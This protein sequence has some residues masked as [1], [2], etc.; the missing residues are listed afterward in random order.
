MRMRSRHFWLAL[1]VAGVLAGCASE[2]VIE[3]APL[4]D[5]TSIEPK[6][7]WSESIGSGLGEGYSR[8]TPAVAEGKVYAADYEGQVEALDAATGDRIWEQNLTSDVNPQPSSSWY[9]FWKW[10]SSAPPART[11]GAVGLGGGLVLVGTLDAEVIAL[12]AATGTEKWRNLVSSEVVAPPAYADGKVLAR[13]VDGKLFALDAETGKRS[14]TYDRTVPILSLRGTSTPVSAHGAAIATFDSGKVS[15]ITLNEGRVIWEK[16]LVPAN[17]RTEFD[18]V[19]D[20]DA[21][22]VVLDDVVYVVSYHGQVAALDLRNGETLWQRELSAHEQLGVDADNV[23]VVDEQSHVRAIERRSGATVWTLNELHDRGL[24]GPVSFGQYVV[25][26]DE[27][28]YVH[29]LDRT[30][31]HYLGRYEL[32]SDGIVSTPIVVDDTLYVYARSGDL[33]AFKLP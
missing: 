32:D 23:Y 29:F 2:D 24:T 25:V 15:A 5:S 28:G 26:G 20:I 31:G 17:G 30:D 3:P 27:E 10:F 8:L 11:A 9:E 14:W 19:G 18:R 7:L 1:A 12:D 4:P 21:D 6:P 22:P 33:A 13:T 16:S